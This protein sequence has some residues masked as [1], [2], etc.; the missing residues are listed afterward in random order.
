VSGNFGEASSSTNNVRAGTE[1]CFGSRVACQ[2]STCLVPTPLNPFGLSDVG[3]R[4]AG[5]HVEQGNQPHV[6]R[7]NRSTVAKQSSISV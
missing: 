3:S 1:V 5:A 4:V 6:M 7:L 2:P